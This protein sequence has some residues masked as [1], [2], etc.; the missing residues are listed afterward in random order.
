MASNGKVS[1]AITNGVWCARKGYN[2]TKIT[3]TKYPEEDNCEL[4]MDDLKWEIVDV[5]ISTYDDGWIKLQSNK[6][7]IRYLV[8]EQL[9]N[10]EFET[11]EF[12]REDDGKPVYLVEEFEQFASSQFDSKMFDNTLKCFNGPLSITDNALYM[13]NGS[14]YVKVLDLEK[15]PFD[16][17][18]SGYG[19]MVQYVDN[20]ADYFDYDGTRITSYDDVKRILYNGYIDVNKKLYIEDVN[21]GKIGVFNKVDDDDW[22]L[23]I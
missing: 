19:Y 15:E 8:S 9:G 10:F 4:E 21:S 3:L 5:G 20:T 22:V 11:M 16:A 12:I 7:N 13:F 2:D 1:L 17:I 18:I 14:G 23:N 6:G